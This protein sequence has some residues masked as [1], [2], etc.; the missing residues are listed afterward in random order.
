MKTVPALK[1]PKP[2]LDFGK[3]DLEL[4]AR[5]QVGSAPRQQSL[6]RGGPVLVDSTVDNPP[7]PPPDPVLEMPAGSGRFWTEDLTESERFRDYENLCTIVYLDSNI[8]RPRI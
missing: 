6:G 7:P 1:G 2:A 3:A 4:R 5:G 8:T